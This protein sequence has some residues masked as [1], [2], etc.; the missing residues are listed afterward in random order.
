MKV[1][2]ITFLVG[3]LATASP[4]QQSRGDDIVLVG[5]SILGAD[6]ERWR[7]GHSIRI[8]GGRITVVGPEAEVAPEPGRL[9]LD[10]RGLHV[11]PGLVAADARLWQ[12]YDGPYAGASELRTWLE[13]GF[14]T[15]RATADDDLL[16]GLL[17]RQA[18]VGGSVVAPRLVVASPV[19]TTASR[20]GEALL[21]HLDFADDCGLDWI[22]VDVDRL[23][24]LSSVELETLVARSRKRGLPL[25]ARATTGPAIRMAI[26]A[27]VPAITTD[28]SVEEPVLALMKERGTVWVLPGS[29]CGV[30]RG[31]VALGPVA[32][33]AA[34]GVP[35]ALG[36]GN[37]PGGNGE[38]SGSARPSPIEALIECGL[39][40]AQAV[41]AA[42]STAARAIGRE[43]D[44]GRIEPGFLGDLV[45]YDRDPLNEPGVLRR[46][47]LVV[48]A[49][50]VVIDRRHESEHAGLARF[51]DRMLE[52]CAPGSMDL[53]ADMF[54]PQA[55]VAG[56]YGNS[57]ELPVR[58]ATQWIAWLRKRAGRAEHFRAW[59]AGPL[60][61]SVDGRF[62]TV[63]AM[64]VVEADDLRGLGRHELR[65]AQADD[66]WRIIA[67][68]YSK[69]Y[70]RTE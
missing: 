38:D 8:D 19:I 9:N 15:V 46:P 32:R 40:P 10:A 3:F 69:R 62:A 11:L 13:A 50:R 55:I 57:G 33:A 34:L 39:S 22:A 20:A 56:D 26:E 17:L 49:G 1:F 31:P 28:W 21:R 23:A 48:K 12:P 29:P 25:L 45:A 5:A 58:T 6:G 65:L 60:R 35:I 2:F 54:G 37:Q 47:V 52:C 41:R 14:T 68:T 4:A 63:S 53:L 66:G 43:R 59:R 44:L 24:D 51:Y 36:G 16:D 70:L 42:T 7:A 30:D 18:S 27:G 61:I 64:A 67:A